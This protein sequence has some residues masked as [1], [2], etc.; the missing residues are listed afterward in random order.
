M[1]DQLP[2][3]K[4]WTSVLTDDAMQALSLEDFARWCFLGVWLR[5]H[6]DGGSGVI[7][8]SSHALTRAWRSRNW[9]SVM[10]ILQ[11][12][13]NVSVEVLEVDP[14][15]EPIALRVAMANWR[16]YQEESSTQRTRAW[17]ERKRKG[18]GQ[19]GVTG[20]GQPASHVTVQT[21]RDE[22]PLP[23]LSPIPGSTDRSTARSAQSPRPAKTYG[24]QSD[25]SYAVAGFMLND[26]EAGQRGMCVKTEH[27]NDVPTPRQ[28]AVHKAQHAS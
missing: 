18:D 19:Q 26:C 23:P 16:K 9:T 11:R 25:G 10:V 14:S 24:R 21:R 4:L 13:P 1:A 5:Q 3:W 17:R 8:R 27:W 2:W 7:S 6:G 20:D 12:L 28:C 22:I 15:G